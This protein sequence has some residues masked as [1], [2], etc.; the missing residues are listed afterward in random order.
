MR[1]GSIFHAEFNSKKFKIIASNHQWKSF[2]ELFYEAI[3]ARK[4]LWK[5]SSIGDKRISFWT[6]QKYSK[7]GGHN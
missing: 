6:F 7:I 3:M 1:E 5:Y 4:N 2:F